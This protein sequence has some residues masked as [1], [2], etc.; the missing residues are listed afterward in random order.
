MN[1]TACGGKQAVFGRFIFGGLLSAFECMVQICSILL[2]A[3]D[4]PFCLLTLSSMELPPPRVGFRDPV[5]GTAEDRQRRHTSAQDRTLEVAG[6]RPGLER[7]VPILLR[8][9]VFLI[10]FISRR[11]H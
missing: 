6:P 10:V 7:V 11:R 4:H 5:F 3:N 9:Q 8:Q 2:F 1:G